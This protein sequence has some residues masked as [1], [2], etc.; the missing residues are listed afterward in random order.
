MCI[1]I[2]TRNMCVAHDIT[3]GWRDFDVVLLVVARN[4]HRFPV[5]GS[6][7]IE[8]IKKTFEILENIRRVKLANAISPVVVIVVV[9]GRTPVVR[10]RVCDTG[11]GGP[12]WKSLRPPSPDR[13]S[14]MRRLIL[15]FLVMHAYNERLYYIIIIYNVRH[16][17]N[18]V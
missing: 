4:P 2:Y 9:V 7:P 10:A 8:T 12:A 17:Y 6:Q 16:M 13:P 1:Y 5:H 15:S 14:L 3:V 11:R 18:I